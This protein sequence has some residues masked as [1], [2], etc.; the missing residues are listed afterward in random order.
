MPPDG[1]VGSSDRPEPISSLKPA[2]ARIAAGA[3]LDEAEA[4]AAFALVMDGAATPAQIAALAMGL[5]VRGEAVSEL[6]G[7]ARAM[8]ARMR[9]VDSVPDAIDVCGTGGDGHATL[10]VSTAVAFVLAALGVPVAKHGNRAVSSRAGASDTLEALG[11]A[12]ESDPA[13]LQARLCDQGLVF[14]AAP[15]HHP[16]MRH[17]GPVRA[18]LGI[19]TLFNLVGPLCNPAG[20]SRQMIGV[21]DPSWQEKLALA[22]RALGVGTAWVVHGE[23]ETGTGLDELG[24]AGRNRVV[25]LKDGAIGEFSFVPEDLGLARQPVS[26]IAGGDAAENARSLELLLAGETG[27]YRDIVLLN[28][29]AALQCSSLQTGAAGCMSG[30][31]P[32]DA[33]RDGMRAASR[34]LD[35]GSALAVLHAQRR[36][37]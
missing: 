21:F 26:A 4:E 32:L 33:L 28:A 7:A 6:V 16:A 30:S 37:H 1:A 23:T 15:L 10:N 35:D 12:L 34:V 25:T 22:L 19:R 13:L 3:I 27:A 20:V 2:L 8:R 14:L 29:S 18:E 24:L 5:R 11:I 9:R 31:A 36:G 17:A